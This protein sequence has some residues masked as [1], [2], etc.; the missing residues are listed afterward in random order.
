MTCGPEFVCLQGSARVIRCLQ[1]HRDEVEFECR[2]AL[3]DQE[4][5]HLPCI[6]SHTLAWRTSVTCAAHVSRQALP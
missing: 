4:V 2:T 5:T 1:D 3:F 6:L